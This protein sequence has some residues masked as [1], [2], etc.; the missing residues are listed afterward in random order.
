VK[1]VFLFFALVL[2]IRLPAQKGMMTDWRDGQEYETIQVGG[3]V[4]MAKNLAYTDANIQSDCYGDSLSN[5]RKYGRLYTWEV[6]NKVCLHGWRLPTKSEFEG[7]LNYAGD[8]DRRKA[9]RV[10][11][12]DSSFGFNVLLGGFYFSSPTVARSTDYLEQRGV[13]SFWTSTEE[14]YSDLAAISR[15]EKTMADI[16]FFGPKESLA[17]MAVFY[18]ECA[19]PVR[20][21]KE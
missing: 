11:T 7:L 1:G 4:W 6:A 18:K 2:S 3:Q 8:G 10:L 9:L 15:H 17:F 20:C 16:V 19:L 21:V 5:C 14:Y 12:A 13:T